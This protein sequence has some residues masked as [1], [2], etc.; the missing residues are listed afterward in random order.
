[1]VIVR[2]LLFVM[3]VLWTAQNAAAQVTAIRFGSLID[4]KG[5]VCKH[6]LL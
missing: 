4:G 5:R 2:T 1:M 6:G 3:V